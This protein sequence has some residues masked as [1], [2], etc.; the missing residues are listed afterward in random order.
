MKREQFWNSIKRYYIDII[1]TGLALCVAYGW[2][3][4][5]YPQLTL[6]ADTYRVVAQDGQEV[7]CDGDDRDVDGTVVYMEMLNADRRQIRFRCRLVEEIMKCLERVRS[8]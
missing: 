5:L 1:A 6:N 4:V 8:K 7:C 2:W 3:G